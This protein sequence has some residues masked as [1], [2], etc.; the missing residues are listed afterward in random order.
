MDYEAERRAEKMSICIDVKNLT[1]RYGT[2][3]VVN[4]LSFEV[5]EGEV[6]GILGHNGAGKSTTIETI[7]G[8]KKADE[9]E[10]LILGKNPRKSRKELFEYIGVQL[11]A[12]H[13]QHNI[14]VREICE[15]MSALYQKPQNYHDLLEKFGLSKFENTFV[16][17]LSGGEKQKLSVVLAL[18]CGPKIV[19]LD[20]LTT[21]LDAAARREVWNLLAELRKEGTTIV[22][23]THY[24]EEA[25]ILCDR[26]CLIREG[27]KVIEGSVLEVIKASPYEKLEDA[28]LWYMDEK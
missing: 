26:I 8:L 5:K 6:Y 27:K 16:E 19:F 22:L 21:G 23:T 11:Q 9:G 14:K 18:L 24:M 1:K 17:K 28:Y 3:M 4:H 7:L 10:V 13:Y 20:E 12:S 25:E 2:R 15:E